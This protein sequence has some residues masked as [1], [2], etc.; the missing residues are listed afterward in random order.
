MKLSENPRVMSFSSQRSSVSRRK[1]VEP[2]VP[3][4]SGF[5][6]GFMTGAISN[7]SASSS[8]HNLFLGLQPVVRV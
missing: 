8:V 3:R 1:A 2:P 4:S 6:G 5:V 7:Y